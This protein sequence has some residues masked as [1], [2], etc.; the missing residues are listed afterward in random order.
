MLIKKIPNKIL[1]RGECSLNYTINIINIFNDND[2]DI[3][4]KELENIVNQKLANLILYYE[5]QN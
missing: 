5:L 4:E 1:Q 3:K 2:V